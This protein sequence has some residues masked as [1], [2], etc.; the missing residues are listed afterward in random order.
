MFSTSVCTYLCSVNCTYYN[1][2]K[3]FVFMVYIVCIYKELC[4]KLP[5]F[6]SFFLEKNMLSFFL[7]IMKQKCG[8]YVCVQLLQT[9]NILFE[10]IRNETS[11]C[12][13]LFMEHTLKV[14]RSCVHW[15]SIHHFRQGSSREPWIQE[16][17]RWRCHNWNEIF[18]GTTKIEWW[19]WENDMLGNNRLRFLLY[20]IIVLE[21]LTVCWHSTFI[22]LSSWYEAQNESEIVLKALQY[23]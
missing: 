2:R 13:Y 15:T 10:N 21:T 3:H 19:M 5:F 11:L 23:I 12:K 7:K 4:F 6:H 20:S 16:N 9:L 14:E 1:I 17:G 18:L 22:A 8:S